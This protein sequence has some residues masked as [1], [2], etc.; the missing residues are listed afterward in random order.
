[1]GT[2][3]EFQVGDKCAEI[4]K[5]AK[6]K[7]E[8]LIC[9]KSGKTLVWS[10][11][12]PLS[13]TAESK[14]SVQG[15]YVKQVDGNEISN[16]NSDFKFDPASSLKVLVALYAFNEMILGK[17][18]LKQ[19][20]PSITS[21]NPRSCSN[22]KSNTSE[23]FQQAIKEMM[24]K[25][26][27]DRTTALIQY[28]SAKKLNNF[29]KSIGLKNTSIKLVDEKPGFIAI[30]CVDPKFD[31]VDPTTVSGNYSTLRD[32]TKI[33]E[34]AN[35]LKEP[36][37]EQFM[38]LTAGREM[39][40]VE[41]YD[42]SGIWPQ[43]VKIVRE[44]APANLSN[45][46]LDQFINLMYSNTKGGSNALCFKNKNCTY[47]RWWVSMINLTKIPYC[48]SGGKITNKT[49]VWG[50]FLA[51]S[52][53]NSAVYEQN[54]SALKNFLNI[55]AEPMREQIRNSLQNWDTCSS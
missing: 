21:S 8:S 49:F 55:G 22:Y 9:V 47:V 37:R 5:T 43:L 4:G 20:F 7:S 1:M 14:N 11:N 17:I 52:D 31:R 39:F 35:N 26:D 13:S 19:T 50:Y 51:K 28:F 41:G 53:S 40:E 32:L 42:Y 33:W 46:S 23:T 38:S 25:S 16:I 36:F 29:S 10:K 15:L 44:E 27:N 54:N 12:K 30:G 6:N 3:P 24:Q 34:N 48:L 18:S 45:V 2:S